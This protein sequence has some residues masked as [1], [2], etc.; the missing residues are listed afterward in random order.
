M[1]TLPKYTPMRAMTFL[2]G[3]SG[4][5]KTAFLSALM[6]WLDYRKVQQID[7]PGDKSGWAFSQLDHMAPDEDQLIYCQ[8]ANGDSGQGN[9][10]AATEVPTNKILTLID[11]NRLTVNKRNHGA[12]DINP[13]VNMFVAANG[14]P[15]CFNAGGAAN[16]VWRRTLVKFFSNKVTENAEADDGQDKGQ[17]IQT[18][19][20]NFGLVAMRLYSV[21]EITEKHPQIANTLNM[22]W[23]MY[24][25]LESFTPMFAWSA[26]GCMT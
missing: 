10:N 7:L 16:S 22:P 6:S 19:A 15:K 1:M 20:G 9:S 11:R 12:T 13:G 14:V 18:Q 23:H 24:A 25:N 3:T 21:R 4:A 8:D 17:L 26:P 5:G 2:E